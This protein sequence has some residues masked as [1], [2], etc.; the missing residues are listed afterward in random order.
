ML[1]LLFCQRGGNGRAVN[2]LN[3]NVDLIS[4]VKM[5]CVVYPHFYGLTIGILD[6]KF[7]QPSNQTPSAGGV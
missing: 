6:I 3:G 5:K 4:V 7:A 1:L 2:V